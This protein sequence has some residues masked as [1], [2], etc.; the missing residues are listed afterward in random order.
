MFSNRTSI[1]RPGTLDHEIS[2]ATDATDTILSLSWSPVANHLAAASWDGK[3]RIY[4][5]DTSAKA[6]S[7]ISMLSATSPVFDCDWTK[8]GT[9]IAAGGADN[10]VHILHLPTG[11]QVTLSSHDKPVRNVCFIDVPAS[12]THVLASGSWDGTVKLWDLR[13]QT[14]LTTIVCRERVYSMDSKSFLLVV[15]TADENIHLI[16]LNN[17]TVI[18]HTQGSPHKDQTKAVAAFPNGM[19]WIMTTIG[20]QGSVNGIGEEKTATDA[21]FRGHREPKDRKTRI[22]DIFSINDVCIHPTEHRVFA[23]AGSDG[24]FIFWDRNASM[25]KL[26]VYPSAGVPLTASAFNHDG[27]FYA[28]ARGYDWS[29]GHAGNNAGIETK[30]MLHAVTKADITLGLTRP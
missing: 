3:V 14:P 22:T 4:D 13:Q 20:G 10:M 19:G 30:L 18:S 8:D 7:G 5:V 11:Q 16:D 24:A 12:H 1:S 23:T 21:I 29:R 9:M 28:Y 27:S 2:L 26:R 17:P 6:A 25:R 15:A